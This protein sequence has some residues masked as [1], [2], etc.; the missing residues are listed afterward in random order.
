MM[1]YTFYLNGTF[2]TV[3]ACTYMAAVETVVREKSKA[4]ADAAIV[5][6]V[7]KAA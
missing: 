2:Y 5:T 4:F 3:Y 7:T 1:A 6:A